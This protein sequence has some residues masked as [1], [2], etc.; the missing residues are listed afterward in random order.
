MREL[1]F[2]VMRI[3][4]FCFYGQLFPA[5][6]FCL[7]W[8]FSLAQNQQLVA[9][10]SL[11][12]IYQC[13]LITGIPAGPSLSSR[14]FPSSTNWLCGESKSV[15]DPIRDFHKLAFGKNFKEIVHTFEEHRAISRASEMQFTTAPVFIY[16]IQAFVECI[17]TAKYEKSREKFQDWASTASSFLG[18]LETRK[19]SQKG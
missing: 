4:L 18:L 12:K 11:L 1:I 5:F 17:V 13:G 8:I 15:T 14:P 7:V 3:G 2:Q 19:K 9:C 10:I 16:Y 6:C